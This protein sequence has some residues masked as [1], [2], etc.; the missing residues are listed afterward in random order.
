M[1]R[2]TSVADA[3]DQRRDAAA[4]LAR[5]A[6]HTAHTVGIT[7]LTGERPPLAHV[8]HALI[9]GQAPDPRRAA[10]GLSRAGRRLAGP[11][12]IE[13]KDAGRAG[14][15]D[16]ALDV[17]AAGTAGRDRAHP[18]PGAGTVEIADL[19]RAGDVLQVRF[20]G[21]EPL[22]T[23]GQKAL[24]REPD[25]ARLVTTFA[26]LGEHG[27]TGLHAVYG[28]PPTAEVVGTEEP[29]D[30]LTIAVG[31]EGH[32]ACIGCSRVCIAI[33]I[34]DRPAIEVDEPRPEAG[35]HGAAGDRREG[36]HHGQRRA[37]TA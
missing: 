14:S 20:A 21:R 17:K 34:A 31:L 13:G 28:H 25:V 15:A 19:L 36:Q 9:C 8:V 5:G 29:R 26:G 12:Q 23:Q 1:G 16:E 7:S 18:H 24:V 37:K 22:L 3:N 4:V 10:T 33:A 6:E 27:L 11:A 2:V 35:R 32:R 30:S